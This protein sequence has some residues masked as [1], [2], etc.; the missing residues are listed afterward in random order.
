M[1]SSH[2]YARRYALGVLLLINP[3]ADDSGAR[4]RVGGVCGIQI[5]LQV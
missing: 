3:T 5:E 4:S 2:G 1:L